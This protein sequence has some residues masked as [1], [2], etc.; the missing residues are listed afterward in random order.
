MGAHR[1]PLRKDINMKK[2][3]GDMIANIA[4]ALL[5]TALCIGLIC[6]FGYGCDRICKDVKKVNIAQSI[7]QFQADIE[8]AKKEADQ[9][10]K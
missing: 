4:G 6:L 1:H 10:R 7:G 5:L 9:E 3:T 8:K 2:E